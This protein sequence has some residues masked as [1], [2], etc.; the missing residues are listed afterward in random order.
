M[1]RT[2]E[3]ARDP[4]TDPQMGDQVRGK[5]SKDRWHI[6]PAATL[7]VEARIGDLVATSSTGDDE[8]RWQKLNTWCETNV[9][10]VSW[11]VIHAAYKEK[12]DDYQPLPI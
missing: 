11:E 8:I 6:G 9:W 3:Q 7:T 12:D 4:R 5:W 10:I 1:T 2:V